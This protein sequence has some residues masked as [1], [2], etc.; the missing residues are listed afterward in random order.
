M[1]AGDGNAK[2]GAEAVRFAADIAKLG[3]KTGVSLWPVTQ[4]PSLSELGDQVVR[5]MLVGGNVVCLRTGDKVSGGMLG[6][7]ADPH[8]LPKFFPGGEPTGGLGYVVGPDNRQA[9]FR[10]SPV[11]ASARRAVPRVPG[12]D[13]RFAEAMA[14]ALQ[15]A[16]AALTAAPGDQ[17]QDADGDGPP[18]RSCADAVEQVLA[19][20]GA[21]MTRADIIK[22]ATDLVLD[23]WKRE[24]A[25]VAR[26]YTDALNKLMKDGK[27]IRVGEKGGGVYQ[28]APARGGGESDATADV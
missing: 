26:S 16:A 23:T 25:F 8:A 19:E 3:R 20:A 2:L 7:E 28:A 24:K 5:S 22:A 12:L 11:P 17:P 4:V 1:F 18:G 10:V 14:W 27:V 21:E 9:P 6:L 13:D 15:P